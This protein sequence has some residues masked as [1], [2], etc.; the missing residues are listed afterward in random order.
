VNSRTAAVILLALA[1]PALDGCIV[2][3]LA[4]G[5]AANH[6]PGHINPCHKN[7]PSQSRC[8]SLEFGGRKRT[9]RIYEPAKLASPAP[10]L[11][12][13]HGLTYNGWGIEGQTRHDF[14][15]LAD[16][17]GALVVYPDGVGQ[18]WND[19]RPQ[20]N[21]A[22]R[23]KIDDIGFL[24][25]LVGALN[26]RYAIDPTRVF[27]AGFSNGAVMT[28][29]LACDA[30]DVFRGFVAVAGS[31]EQETANS[32]HPTPRRVMLINGTSDMLDPWGGWHR[33]WGRGYLIGAEATFAEFRAI[34]GCSG[35]EQEPSPAEKS[36][37]KSDVIEHRAVGCQDNSSVKLFEVRGGGH[38]WPGGSQLRPPVNTHFVIEREGALQDFVATRE[39]WQFLGLEGTQAA[40]ATA[41]G[42]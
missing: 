10:L 12:V 27:V 39:A 16:Q 41:S 20:P 26:Q 8:E 19:Q 17:A 6:V 38:A 3:G 24:R 9:Y 11:V 15:R 36:S 33:P 21:P 23:H 28:L 18:E 13:L 42:R 5:V 32:C 2:A 34:A 29:Y 7:D 4:V 22:G 14:D 31:L 25:A 35:V 40:P 30:S 1:V 37:A